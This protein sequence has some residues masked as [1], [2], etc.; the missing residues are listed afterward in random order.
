[1]IRSQCNDSLFFPFEEMVVCIY[2]N[3]LDMSSLPMFLDDV[4][5]FFIVASQATYSCNIANSNIV[6]DAV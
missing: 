2:C 4:S 1:M 3:T 6:W 5:V